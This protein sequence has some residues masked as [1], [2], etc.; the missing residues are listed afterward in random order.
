MD[1]SI[2]NEGMQ[3]S[4][5]APLL[6]ISRS[7]LLNEIHP[8][9]IHACEEHHSPPRHMLLR[10]SHPRFPRKN[11]GMKACALYLYQQS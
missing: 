5:A 11:N 6:R 7:L 1:S 4:Q 9:N 2:D 10:G 8:I 3:T